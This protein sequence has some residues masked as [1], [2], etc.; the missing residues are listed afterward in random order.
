MDY[1]MIHNW[2]LL[3]TIVFLLLSLHFVKILKF[4]ESQ[5]R[6]WVVADMEAYV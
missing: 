1:I 5:A 2:I 3:G 6:I 4:I